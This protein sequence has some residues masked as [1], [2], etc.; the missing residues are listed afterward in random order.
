MTNIL[1]FYRNYCT[2]M[3]RLF[4]ALLLSMSMH[5]YAQIDGNY[6][7]SVGVKAFNMMQMPKMLQQS[8]TEDYKMS[9]ANGGIIRFNDN[10]MSFRI[11]GHY[12]SDKDYSFNNKCDNCE[13][14]QGTLT[15]W[16]IKLGFEKN[17]NYSILQPYFAFDVGFRANKFNG[18]MYSKSN[19]APPYSAIAGKN[20]LTLSPIIGLKFNVAKQI[21]VFAESNLEFYI[22]Y[23]R[24]ETIMS[25]PG[26]TRTFVKYNKFEGLLNPISAG[27]QIHLVGRD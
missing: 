22:S 3:K 27:I 4:L 2:I 11:S 20:G 12:L 14:A 7:Y 13:T 18:D 23:E 17:F 25:D 21:S 10:Q 5:T 1:Y 26:H 6:N 19:A 16:A 8:N 15:D 9:T 24:Q